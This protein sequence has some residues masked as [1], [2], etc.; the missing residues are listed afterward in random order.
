MFYLVEF[1]GIL[2]WETDFFFGVFLM[3]LYIVFI[4]FT[5]SS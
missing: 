5:T 4:C 2:L 3:D 1:H